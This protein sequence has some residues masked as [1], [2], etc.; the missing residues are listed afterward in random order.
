MFKK[1]LVALLFLSTAAHAQNRNRPDLKHA[2]HSYT[3]AARTTVADVAEDNYDVKYVKLD[4]AVS[5]ISTAITGNVI[6]RATVVAAT[7]GSYV[8]EL[9]TLLTI[10]SVLIN[11]SI[12]TVTSSGAIRTVAFA[13]PLT[14]GTVFTAQVFYHGTPLSGTQYDIRGMNTFFDSCFTVIIC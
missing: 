1:L 7:M 13:A 4:V 9:D 12:R 11:G 14:S 6:T 3:N 8:F 5:N 10:D 2:P